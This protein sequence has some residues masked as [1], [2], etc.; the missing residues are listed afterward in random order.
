MFIDRNL[1]TCW[2]NSTNL[3]FLAEKR[4]WKVFDFLKVI[5]YALNLSWTR[6]QGSICP[7]Q[8][9]MS[10]N[11]TTQYSKNV[12]LSLRII[13]Q[14]QSSLFPF[15]VTTKFWSANGSMLC[16][17]LRLYPV[18]EHRCWNFPM[19]VL[20]V[21][22]IWCIVFKSILWGEIEE[23]DKVVNLFVYIEGWMGNEAQGSWSPEAQCFLKN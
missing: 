1:K 5:I 10:I 19:A 13:T 9:V 18:A 23:I 4:F 12:V 6:Q 8:P 3:N 2:L 15:F 16:A 21:M 20:C 11:I 14:L 7:Q 22:T 17:F